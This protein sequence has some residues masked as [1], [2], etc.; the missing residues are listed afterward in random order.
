MKLLIAFL[1]FFL[2]ATTVAILLGQILKRKAEENE[3]LRW[4]GIDYRIR[5][6]SLSDYERQP[7]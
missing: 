1:I 5:Y 2:F 4:M 3:A 6:D 7:K